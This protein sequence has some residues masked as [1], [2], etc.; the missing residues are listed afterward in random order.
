[1]RSRSFLAMFAGLCALCAQADD[2]SEFWNIFD[3]SDLKNRCGLDFISLKAGADVRTAYLSRGKVC[4]ARPMSSQSVTADIMLDQFHVPGRV[5]IDFWTISSLTHKMDTIHKNMFFQE[6]DFTLRY[7]YDWDIA[8]DW[9]LASDVMF[10]WVTL[11]GYRHDKGLDY[12]R[13]ECRFAQR[14]ENPWVTPYYLLRRA[15]HPDDWLYVRVGAQHVFRLTDTLSLTPNFYAECGNDRHFRQRYGANDPV[16]TSYTD[17]VQAL[18]AVLTLSWKVTK[19]A[20]IFASVQQFDIVD[21][22]ARDRTKA[23]KTH[24]SRRDL[25]VGTIGVVCRF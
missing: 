19:W 12:C 13:H 10:T 1:M 23:K 3:L 21:D 7:G 18:N 17:G 6:R 5:G 2:P 20:S 15:I 9:R 24:N 25:T 14:L 16:W 11:P 4:E 8:D 22:D